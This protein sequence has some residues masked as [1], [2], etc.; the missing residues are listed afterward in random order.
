[1][2]QFSGL[3]ILQ[4][5]RK[6]RRDIRKGIN[7]QHLSLFM[8]EEGVELL[9]KETLFSEKASKVCGLRS[10]TQIFSVFLNKG[11]FVNNYMNIFLLPKKCDPETGGI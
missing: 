9:L 5:Q 4:S 2:S 8:A 3:K 10:G 11:G 7:L 1:M 6:L